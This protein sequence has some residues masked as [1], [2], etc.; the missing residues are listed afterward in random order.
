MTTGAGSSRVVDEQCAYLSR[1]RANAA[2]HVPLMAQSMRLGAS[3]AAASVRI[4]R[5]PA[6]SPWSSHRD[7][8]A[9]AATLPGRALRRRGARAEARGA[10]AARAALGIRDARSAR[11]LDACLPPA[12][13][14]VGRARD[15][16]PI[17]AR[18]PKARLVAVGERRTRTA[19][20]RDARLPRCAVDRG[21]TDTAVA[22]QATLPS[23]AVGRG[24]ARAQPPGRARGG[25]T[26]TAL[27]I[28]RA[29]AADPRG[30]HHSGG[31]IGVGIAGQ[32]CANARDAGFARNAVAV[33]GARALER[34]VGGSALR[35][36]AAFIVR[37]TGSTRPRIAY[38]AGRTLAVGGAAFAPRAAWFAGQ[39][40]LAHPKRL[41]GGAFAVAPATV[42]V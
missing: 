14:A 22:A 12:T 35:A 21:S 8:N 3:A 40:G 25:R 41:S 30:T 24:G 42:G 19:R 36:R 5:S 33:D 2:R 23:L 11:A 9:R 31:T 15:T 29:G 4:R 13:L 17:H 7:A 32:R 18:K 1:P 34:R 20:S 39:V 28:G 37:C 6:R 10:L 38:L 16:R 27:A 26:R